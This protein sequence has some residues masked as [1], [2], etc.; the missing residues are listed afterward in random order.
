MYI[1]FILVEPAVPE[2]VGASARAM[3]TM[4]FKNLRLVD[5]CDYLNDK[6]K[7]LAHGSHVILERATVYPSLE[8]ALVD[9]DFV[10]GTTAKKRSAKQDYYPAIQLSKHLKEKGDSISRIAI[11]FGR[12]ESG[13]T[14]EEIKLCDL[15]S[16][17]PMNASYPSL[18]LSQAVMIYGYLLSGFPQKPGE[19]GENIKKPASYPPLKERVE[20]ILDQTRI[21]ENQTLYKRIMERVALLGEGDIHLMH[22]VTE[23]LLTI[24]HNKPSKRQ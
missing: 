14:N 22:S 23:Q 10:I 16:S 4:G 18:N 6:A 3:N 11:V 9:I 24:L 12:E 2:N 17:I 19:S 5:P 1:T 20:K 7:M 8:K 15:V 21:R 13:L